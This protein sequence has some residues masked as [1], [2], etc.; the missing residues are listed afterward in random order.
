VG[1]R[2]LAR[3]GSA[4]I[5]EKFRRRFGRETTSGRFIH[6]PV[7]SAFWPEMWSVGLPS[8]L[9]TLP[10][11]GLFYLLIERPCMDRRWPRRLASWWHTKVLK[12][13]HSAAASGTES[14]C[15]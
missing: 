1:G 6:R 10:I 12:S 14:A 11:C 5:L 15:E 7:A 2:G 9:I 8:L 3:D 4:G 13:A